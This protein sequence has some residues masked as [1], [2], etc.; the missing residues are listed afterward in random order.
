MKT[1]LAGLALFV[2]LAALAGT[3][4]HASPGAVVT[5]P[6]V[7]AEL[8]AH[9][10]EGVQAGKPMWLGLKI[11][12]QPHWHTYWKNPGDSG[13]PTTLN[14]QLPAGV[15]AGPIEW[16]TPLRLPIGPLMN[17]GYEGTLLLP[18]ALAVPAGWKGEAL[19]I[20]LQATWLVCKDVCI[21]EN[22]DF[23]LRLP[24]QAATAGH[25][26]LFEAAR[27]ATPQT[28]AA[29]QA[30][31][32]VE[33]GA[34]LL[35]VAGLPAAWQGR[36]LRF[37]PETSGLIANA[38]LQQG[39]WQ[40]AEWTA[41]VPL[42]EQRTD[43]PNAIPAVL[44]GDGAAGVQLQVA[45]TTPWPAAAAP[46]TP[47]AAP[48]PAAA[49][50]PPPQA[51]ASLALSLGLALLGGMLLNLM[52]C[53]FPVLSLKVLGFAAHA[54]EPDARRRLLAGGIAYTVGVVLSFV[55]LAALLLALRAGGEQLGWGFQLQQP[56]VVAVLAALFT[57]IGLNLAG[58]FEFS[59]VLPSAWASARARHPVV[60]SALT[61]VLAVAVA[62][63]CTAPFMGASLGAAVTLPTAQALA[64]FAALGLGMALPYLA[65]SAWPALARR[66]PRPG[67]WMAHF[68]SLMAF[69]MFAT[70]VW[71]VWVLGQQSGIDGAAAL[72]GLLVALAFAAWALGS[73]AL[74]PRARAGFGATA[75]ALLAV[76][77]FWAVPTLRHEAQAQVTGAADEWQPWSAERV[78]QALAEGRPVFVDFTA[79]WCV[80]CQFNK[81]TA[82]ADRQVKA[83]FAAARVLLLRADWTRR[84]AAISAEL[85]RM[86]RSGVP[87]YV[88]HAPGAP[89]P[90]LLSEILSTDELRRTVAALPRT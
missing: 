1:T 82:L 14:W 8:V 44:A 9:A 54:A 83:D 49:P 39:R 80:T 19:D 26:A 73:P 42:D 68:K 79:A 55:T 56:A 84:D 38:G 65:A 5:T 21:P 15:A 13:L 32:T 29:A 57:L 86:G 17:F 46:G 24:A 11:E 72:L 85:A 64:V 59:S 60:D 30:T 87:V 69:P 45:V 81:R 34:L 61:G 71:L 78:S 2:A 25:G 63:P 35:R 10:P 62:S 67:V 90:V 66:L 27:A 50:A 12:H 48:A 37:F 43:A 6:Q 76:A 52:P 88:F 23:A 75:L 22:G 36:E 40:G 41:R 53:V 58:V 51:D 77:L 20:K 74:G 70:V 16:P 7:R 33:P 28:L 4:A 31:A 89:A 18:V 3:G 47:G